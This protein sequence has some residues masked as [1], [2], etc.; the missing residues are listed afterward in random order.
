MTV[1]FVSVKEDILET[2][3]FNGTLKVR[4]R[5][6]ISVDKECLDVRFISDSKVN[7]RTTYSLSVTLTP[8]LSSVDYMRV[9]KFRK[10]L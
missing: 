3:H 8:P 2:K 4:P 7:S 6:I 5:G 1:L 10:R 9:L